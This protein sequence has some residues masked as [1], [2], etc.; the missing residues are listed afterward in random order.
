MS[1]YDDEKVIRES[2][3]TMLSDSRFNN[4]PW[5]RCVRAE[6]YGVGV[7]SRQT[8]FEV[9]GKLCLL[10]NRLTVESKKKIA[11]LY[12]E[13]RAA[14]GL[15]VPW[16]AIVLVV[17]RGSRTGYLHRYFG[18][19]AELWGGMGSLD[20]G[21]RAEA[22]RLAGLRV[23]TETFGATEF[24]LDL[25]GAIDAVA[26]YIGEN[27]VDVDAEA[28]LASRFDGGW[29]VFVPE[30]PSDDP[31]DARLG[32]VYFLVSDA[33]RVAQVTSSVPPAEAISDFLAQGR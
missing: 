20:P 2:V 30:D 18:S 31:L 27:R 32:R 22:A 1:Q 14:S 33:G 16:N 21:M 23:S 28:L 17:D 24:A 7:V 13:L 11:G 19:A 25:S 10:R 6:Y 15:A 9:D 29:R 8:F 5:D 26:G 3:D 4:D 12:A